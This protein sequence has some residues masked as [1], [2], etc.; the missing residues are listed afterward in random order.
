MNRKE[1]LKSSGMAAFALTTI[2]CAVPRASQS[3]ELPESTHVGDCAT[4]NDILGPF[5]RPDAPE[6]SDMTFSGLS[7]SR[8]AIKGKVYTDDCTSILENVK[9]E[10]WHCDTKGDYDN[11]SSDFRHRAQQTTDNAGAYSFKTIL[12]GKYLN[13]K[14][15]RPAHIHFRVTHEEHQE[16]ISQIY[17]A[18][19]PH[20][21]EDPWASQEK[22]KARI[23][24][25][26]LEDT[27]GNLTVQFDIYLNKLA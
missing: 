25:I 27:E 20:I 7:G 17:F 13:G 18:G 21:D 2:G 1:F 10:I 14:L 24:P 5:Y 11:T 9:V 16:L 3:T 6:K 22:A 19:D 4:T 23:L 26:V 8:V 15:Y 12:P